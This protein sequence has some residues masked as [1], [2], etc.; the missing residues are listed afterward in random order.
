MREQ[1]QAVATKVREQAQAVATKV[2]EQA[3]GQL[4]V[5]A[6][7]VREQVLEEVTKARVHTN[8]R[9]RPNQYRCLDCTNPRHCRHATEDCDRRQGFLALERL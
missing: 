7:K 6:T 5:V 9:S 4:R 1:A 2:R 8:S 3:Q